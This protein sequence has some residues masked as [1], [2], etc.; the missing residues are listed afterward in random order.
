MREIISIAAGLWIGL[1]GTVAAQSTAENPVVVELYTSQGGS[2]CPPADKVL[3]GLAQR[4]DVIALAL[5]VDY[6]DYIGWK[7]SFAEPGYSNRQRAYARFAGA[8]TVYTPQ[9]IVDGMDRLVGVRAGELEA[10]V[11]RHSAIDTPVRITLQRQEGKVRI[12]AR[13]EVSLPDDCLVQ[14]VRYRPLERVTIERGENAGKVLDY[15]N[16]VT[17]WRRIAKWDGKS[18][19]SMTADAPGDDAIAVIIQEEGPGQIL[20]A[21]KLR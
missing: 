21:A 6:W 3:Q 20:A 1:A 9:M 19:L 12:S 5:H 7:D 18:P 17:D 4:D 15:A 11:K 13:S 8:R 14:L 16:I 2:S 10:L